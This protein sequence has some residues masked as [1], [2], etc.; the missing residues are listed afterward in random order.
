MNSED[1]ERLIAPAVASVLE[2]M[3]FAEAEEQSEPCFDKCDLQA[4]VTFFGE[5]SGILR[6]RLGE[7]S[8]RSLSASFLGEDEESLSRIQLEQVV[9]ELANMLCGW[10]VSRTERDGV[11]RLGSPELICAVSEEPGWMQQSFGVEHGALTVSLS[12]SVPV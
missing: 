10:I 8:A 4:Q 7:Q 5:V 3:F 2:S 11:W 12:L 9:C 6:V 1:F